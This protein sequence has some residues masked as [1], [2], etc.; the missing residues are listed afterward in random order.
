MARIYLRHFPG[1]CLQLILT[2]LKDLVKIVFFEPRKLT[3]L[4]YCALGL[5]DG[6]LGRVGPLAS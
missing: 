5:R 1:Y 4:K 2:S 3:K 6:L